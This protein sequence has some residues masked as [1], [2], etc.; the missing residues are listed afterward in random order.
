MKTAPGGGYPGTYD[1]K[2]LVLVADANQAFTWIET[3]MPIFK[4]VFATTEKPD[5]AD[6]TGTNIKGFTAMADDDLRTI[7][8]IHTYQIPGLR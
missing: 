2:V 4:T 6:F 8:Y 7:D 5:G 1:G 3:A